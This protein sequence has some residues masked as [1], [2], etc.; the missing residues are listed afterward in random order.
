VVPVRP[1]PFGLSRRGLPMTSDELNG[2]RAASR[3][4]IEFSAPRGG[5]RQVRAITPAGDAMAIAL[6][7]ARLLMLNSKARFSRVRVVSVESE[8][9]PDPAADAIDY[10]NT[11]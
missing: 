5:S 7:T 10:W 6:A 9:V 1:A 2:S 4:T 11:A 3:Y 8:F